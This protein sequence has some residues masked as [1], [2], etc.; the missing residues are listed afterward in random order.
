MNTNSVLHSFKKEVS[1]NL[2]ISIPLIASQLIYATSGF[3]GTALV[4]HLGEEALAAS[5]LVSTIWMSLSV[6]FFGVLNAVS[7]L[8]S[9]AY[10]AEDHKA[11]SKIMGQSMILGAIVSVI[12]IAVLST[13]PLFLNL[14]NQ[15]EHVKV[16]ATAYMR[17][18]LWTIPS[19]ILLI[20][21]EQFLAGINRTKL[22]LRIS[23]LIVP[24][25]IPLIYV[26]IFGKFGM[27]AFGVAGIGYGFAT[28][29]TLVSIGMIIHFLRSSSLKHYDIFSSIGSFHPK[30]LFELIRVGFPIGCM[31]VI[32]V[33]TFTIA[34]FW[35]AKFGTTAL[36]AHQIIMQYLGFMITMVFAMSQAVTVRV[37]HAIGSQ[38]L[39]QIRLAIIVGLVLDLFAVALIVFIFICL[40][41][42]ILH[43]DINPNDPKNAELV[44]IAT[45]LFTIAAILLIFDNFRIIGFGALRGLK[46]TT[47][48][49]IAS[50]ISFWLIGLSSAYYF[51]IVNN[52]GGA[53]VW[54]GL[55]IGI[56][57]GAVIVLMRTRYLVNQLNIVENGT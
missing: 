18:L 7:V 36:A 56:A 34:T 8:V 33:S 10:G 47:F 52:M 45:K 39:D 42:Y 26:L 50:L 9:H 14:T 28:T 25:E 2:S 49:M 57:S 46:D 35:I 21:L 11:I 44:K 16:L 51:G 48:P 32:E 41:T 30:I 13:M 3:V 43:F 38:S 4:A 54:C 27:P 31:H 24:L 12:M 19:L 1:N 53:G 40:P 6:L 37:G 20:I 23:L 5:V 17:A 55:T 29:Y 22:V 15:P